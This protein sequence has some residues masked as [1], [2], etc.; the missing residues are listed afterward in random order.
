[1]ELKDLRKN[2]RGKAISIE[3]GDGSGKGTLIKNIKKEFEKNE[4]DTIFTREPGGTNIS[5]QIRNVILSK[6]NTE[7]SPV[8]EMI[9]YAAAR[10]QHF[11]E[12]IVPT[13]KSGKLLILDRF[14]DSN[15]VYQGFVR[16]LGIDKVMAVNKIAIG[17]WLPDLTIILDIDPVIG[18]NR[19]K[20]N[21]RE[22][23]RL[24]LQDLEF[25][26]KVREGYYKIAEM[27][28]QRIKMI[29][30]SQTPE[31]VLDDTIKTII[32]FFEKK[33]E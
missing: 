31:K 23:N 19:I 24:D 12:L 25:H 22:T 9:L 15:Y 29:D 21:G 13:L 18:L 16:G 27:F 8:T 28:P 32:D 2:L 10:A 20:N 3:G 6:E 5:E 4:I 26:N 14:I 33:D 17:N 30:A 7:M 1:M 11:E